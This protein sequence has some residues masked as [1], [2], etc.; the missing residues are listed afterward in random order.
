L[1]WPNEPGFVERASFLVQMGSL[2]V[3]K[4]L[5]NDPDYDVRQKVN[6]AIA[7]FASIQ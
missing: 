2:K 7:N 5:Q 4:S 3:L 1:T 6:C